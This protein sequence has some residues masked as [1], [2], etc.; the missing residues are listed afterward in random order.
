MAQQVSGSDKTLI[1]AIR[2]GD[3]PAPP[4]LDWNN[5]Q[6][7]RRDIGLRPVVARDGYVTSTTTELALWKS[8]MND[9]HGDDWLLNLARGEP[10][11]AAAAAGEPPQPREPSPVPAAGAGDPTTPTRRPAIAVDG[12]GS[13]ELP[14]GAAEPGSG[15]PS[16]APSW[17]SRA[18]GT[19]TTLGQNVLR[20]YDPDSE[21]VE[22]YQARVTKQ[23]EVLKRLGNRL[24]KE[25]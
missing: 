21:A 23:A 8:V 24:P 6:I 14:P 20:A 25:F 5:F 1:V 7:W 17:S 9:L 11:E 16:P 3:V 12:P 4:L 19:P 2:D 13:G 10:P 15:I 18:P 22:K